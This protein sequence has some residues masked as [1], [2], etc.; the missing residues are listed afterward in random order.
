[1]IWKDDLGEQFEKERSE[2][3]RLKSEHLES[4]R[5][6]GEYPELTIF[7]R[8]IRTIWRS[9]LVGVFYTL[10]IFF[11]GTT[12]TR[13][14]IPFPDLDK[15]GM[16]RLWFLGA[17]ILMG[18]VIGGISQIVHTSK[19]NHI[20][21][22]TIFLFLNPLSISLESAL[23]AP[24]LLAAQT[25]PS[26]MLVQFL[27]ALVA[28]LL[29]TFLFASSS[30]QIF[31]SYIHRPWSA[32]VRRITISIII[33]FVIFLLFSATNY[34]LVKKL[35]YDNYQF[36]LET[37]TFPLILTIQFM[38]AVLIVFSLIP[39]ITTIGATKRFIAVMSGISL[40]V[41]GALGPF[42]QVSNLS[43]FL[44]LASSG[45]LFIQYFLIGIFV[46]FI[47][48]CPS[49]LEESGTTVVE[50]VRPKLQ[51]GLGNT[52]EFFTKPFRVLDEAQPE[53]EKSKKPISKEPL[54][55]NSEE[56]PEGGIEIPK[57][58]VSETPPES[59]ENEIP[60]S[61][62]DT[63]EIPSNESQENSAETSAPNNS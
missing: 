10:T 8:I 63:K 62:I 1:M 38:K 17:S 60:S 32:W 12:L 9:I 57:E 52:A 31:G 6:V 13:Q 20:L 44:L 45:S 46:G 11:L 39:M 58:S 48:G 2:I 40:V 15:L 29:I 34:P 5:L 24:N 28:G 30:K 14:G 21:T 59:S 4:E 35:Y 55:N 41:L 3:E 42:L 61:E 51:K 36:S 33:T 18:F 23:L 27:G 22:W 50:Y 16:N 54:Q 43:M 37:P 47:L 53:A 56:S 7:Q 25:L 49:K 26:L 19:P